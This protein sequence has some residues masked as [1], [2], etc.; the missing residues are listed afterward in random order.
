MDADNRAIIKNFVE[1]QERVAIFFSDREK[2]LGKKK[3]Y[4]DKVGISRTTFDR[5]LKGKSFTAEELETLIDA[6]S[7]K[8]SI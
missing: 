3:Y 1:L 2:G 8:F 6:I 7:E 5:K 4:W